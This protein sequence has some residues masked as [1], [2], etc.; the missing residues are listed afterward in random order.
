M[1]SEVILSPNTSQ[2]SFFIFFTNFHVEK[3]DEYLDIVFAFG[4]FGET[5]EEIFEKEKQLISSFIDSIQKRDTH[6]GV[7]EIGPR[8]KVCSKI[9]QYRDHVRLKRHVNLVRRSG[10]ATGLG[11]ALEVA[12]NMFENQARANSKRVL[13]VF[14]N[15]KSGAQVTKSDTSASL[16]E[17]FSSLRQQT[18]FR[19]T[20]VSAKRNFR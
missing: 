8:A 7:I 11:H 19:L 13:V 6:Y 5:A 2:R 10:D 9:G 20:L 16:H 15:G 1:A 18:I 14:T 12:A 17:Q 4:S 3:Q